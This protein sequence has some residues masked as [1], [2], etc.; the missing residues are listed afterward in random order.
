MTMEEKRIVKNIYNVKFFNVLFIGW[1]EVLQQT[2][3]FF[4]MNFSSPGYLPC[5]RHII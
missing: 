5:V 2:L 4:L 3:R 1:E